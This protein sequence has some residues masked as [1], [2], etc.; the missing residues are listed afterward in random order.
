LVLWAG[1][2]PVPPGPAGKPIFFSHAGEFGAWLDKNAGSAPDCQVGYWKVDTGK[3]S[4][5]WAQS[6]EQALIH[7]WI[8]GRRHSLGD[9]AYTIRFTPRKPGSHWSLVNVRTAKTLV[10]Q[11]RMKP[12]GLAAF[13]ARSAKNTGQASYARRHAA[14]FAGADLRRFRTNATAWAW[15]RKSP[16]SYQKGCA[17]WVQSAKKPETR[18]RRLGQVILHSAKGETL[19]QYRWAKKPGSRRRR[20]VA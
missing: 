3:P 1:A 11:G 19:P 2:F 13:K 12:A 9:D 4:L 10:K 16:P 8:D 14:R 20:P 6:V 5:T 15:F 17:W 7:G 18:E